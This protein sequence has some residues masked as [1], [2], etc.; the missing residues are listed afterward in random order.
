VS[1]PYGPVVLEHF[2]RPRNRGALDAPTA[3]A[4]A[5]NPLCG[6]RVRIELAIERGAV[7]EA[8][9][10]ADACALCVASASLLTEMA[11][12]R[13]TGVALAI[14][15][16][17]IVAALAVDVPPARDRCVHLPLDAMR[18]ALARA[19]GLRASAIV[20]AAG[21]GARFGGGKLVAPIA[22]VPLVRRTVEGVLAS[23]VREVIV[24]VGADE[25]RVRDA[26]GGLALRIVANVDHGEGMGGSLRVGIDALPSD[27]DAAL[28][29]LG[30]QPGVDARII[31]PLLA[32]MAERRAAIVVPSYR[33]ARGTPVLFARATFAEL[34]EVRGDVG[35]REVV[36][37]DPSRVSEVALDR[38][39]PPDVDTPDALDALAQSF[40]AMGEMGSDADSESEV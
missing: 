10:V 9:F 27:S 1:S 6:D 23:G 2:R 39:E 18:D 34:R 37:R 8:R 15:V 22:G 30:D 17:E 3:A 19:V 21:S 13:S 5:T 28:V 38:D 25:A 32:A 29:A 26:L 20:L 16:S 40:E 4:E 12:G 7:V 33:G 35:G 14:D 31:D 11:R 36:R 24:V